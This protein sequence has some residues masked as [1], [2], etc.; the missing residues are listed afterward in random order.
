MRRARHY[1]RGV[2]FAL[3]RYARRDVRHLE[4]AISHYY[5]SKS[6]TMFLMAFGVQEM[7]VGRIQ[8]AKQCLDKFPQALIFGLRFICKYS[9]NLYTAKISMYMVLCT[10]FDIR[11]DVSSLHCC[12]I[13]TVVEGMDDHSH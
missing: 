7:A 5:V 9:E 10:T 2:R 8:V 4:I 13:V 6:M 1:T 11:N 3:A 12:R